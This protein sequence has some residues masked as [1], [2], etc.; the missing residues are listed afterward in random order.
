MNKRYTK[1][2]AVKELERMKWEFDTGKFNGDIPN[3]IVRDK[4]RDDTANHLTKC[5]LTYI[6]IHRG[7][8][9]RIN[10]MGRP[11]DNRKTFTDVVGRTRTI[12]SVEWAKG[13]TTKGSADISATI[14]GQS[15]KIEVKVGRDRQSDPQ[16]AYQESIEA[17]GGVY[18]IARDFTD[19]KTWFDEKFGR[20]E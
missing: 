8:A 9:E 12:G 10:T 2:P 11:I 5:I 17:A 1:S 13:N 19:F 14:D 4:F 3:W 16:R 15:V 7:Q 6:R 20:H 18:F